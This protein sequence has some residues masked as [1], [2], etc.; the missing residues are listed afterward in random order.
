MNPET[1]KMKERIQEYKSTH[2]YTP[3]NT[4]TYERIK[5]RKRNTKKKLTGREVCYYC[6]VKLTR[7]NASFD[8]IVPLSR[9][10]EDEKWNLV[11]CCKKCNMSK[12]YKLLSE[13]EDRIIRRKPH[14]PSRAPQDG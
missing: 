9:G 3:T 8:H 14:E 12:G 1:R 10:G 6:G 2:T 7:T 5:R 13:W 4:H 11:W